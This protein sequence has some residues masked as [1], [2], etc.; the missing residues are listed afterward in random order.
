MDQITTLSSYLC[1]C[2]C[3]VA[4]LRRMQCICGSA[5][6]GKVFG[7]FLMKNRRVLRLQEVTQHLP[8]LP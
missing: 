6:V 1:L 5:V 3:G 2:R 4:V 8:T 7:D